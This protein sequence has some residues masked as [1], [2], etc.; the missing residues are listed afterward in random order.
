M[1][2]ENTNSWAHVPE[3]DPMGVT[4]APEAT[5]LTTN[6]RD[7]TVGGPQARL[8]EIRIDNLIAAKSFKVYSHSQCTALA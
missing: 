5:L 2:T 4:Q 3:S 1:R 7:T 8:G 6:L